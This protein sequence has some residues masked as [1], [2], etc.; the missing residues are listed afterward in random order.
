MSAQVVLTEDKRKTVYQN[1]HTSIPSTVRRESTGNH[2]WE[3]DITDDDEALGK[4]TQPDLLLITNGTLPEELFPVT[5]SQ[6]P[7]KLNANSIANREKQFQAFIQHCATN[8]L[9][10]EYIDVHFSHKDDKALENNEVIKRNGYRQ[11]F[12]DF[13]TNAEAPTH[14]HHQTYQRMLRINHHR[15]GAP[16]VTPFGVN[17]YGI[18]SSDAQKMLIRLSKVRFPQTNNCLSYLSARQRWIDWWIRIIQKY[19]SEAVVQGIEAGFAHRN[20]LAADLAA[21]PHN[22]LRSPPLKFRKLA[23]QGDSMHQ[24]NVTQQALKE[25]QSPS[26]GNEGQTIRTLENN[27]ELSEYEK[28]RNARINENQKML[29]KNER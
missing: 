1:L 13:A 27:D 17:I 25:I 23:G 10:Y 5:T 20:R 12:Q 6:N 8:G 29:R 24:E 14:H 11:A 21:S 9:K 4:F 18:L 15:G 26:E 7:R 16:T 3:G 22:T 2:T 28:N 19:V